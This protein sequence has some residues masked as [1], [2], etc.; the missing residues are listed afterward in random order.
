MYPSILTFNL[1]GLYE[2]GKLVLGVLLK[3]NNFFKVL[4]YYVPS[5]LF[6]WVRGWINCS[7]NQLSGLTLLTI[8]TRITHELN[9]QSVCPN[10]KKNS[11]M[12]VYSAPPYFHMCKF[13]HSAPRVHIIRR[14]CPSVDKIQNS[15][16]LSKQG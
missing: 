6:G 3:T 1:S 5:F 13:L 7:Y 10:I 4:F 11:I 15:G 14:V 16:N 12:Q 8:I 2:L 9:R